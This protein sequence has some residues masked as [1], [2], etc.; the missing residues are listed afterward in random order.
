MLFTFSGKF[1]YGFH[2]GNMTAAIE[3]Y[4]WQFSQQNPDQHVFSN[5][6]WQ[7]QEN[8][9]FHSVSLTAE[10]CTDG[11]C[12]HWISVCYIPC[13]WLHEQYDVWPEAG[14]KEWTTL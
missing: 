1:V 2:N 6:H 10:Y 12:G 3:E 11:H 7:L 8:G 5:V 14:H 13:V 4:W 9:L